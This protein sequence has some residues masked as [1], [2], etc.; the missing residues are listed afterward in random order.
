MIFRV[1]YYLILDFIWIFVKLKL[2]TFPALANQTILVHRSD[3]FVRHMQNFL[4]CVTP[5]D[6]LDSVAHMVYIFLRRTFQIRPGQDIK[7]IFRKLYYLY[8]YKRKPEL[9]SQV[10]NTAKCYENQTWG[11]LCRSTLAPQGS[12][13]HK[14][15]KG[16]PPI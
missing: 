8:T 3:G 5:Y 7:S 11:A 1:S 9:I 10:S 6:S 16:R 15:F 4:D 14:S 2:V 12:S 13:N